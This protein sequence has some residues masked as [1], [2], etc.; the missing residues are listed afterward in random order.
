ME[1]P[2]VIGT[3]RLSKTLGIGAFGKARRGVKLAEHVTTGHKVAVK[4]LNRAKI[5]ALDMSEKVKREINILQRC[6]HPHII[7]LYEVIDTPTD[8]FVVME[9][10]SNGELFDYI[11]SKGRL[12]PDEA[13]HFFHQIISG[14]EYCHYHHIVHRD[15]K[16]ENLLLDADNNIKIADFGL[17]NVMR[18]GEFLR[19]SCGSPNYAAPEVISGHLYAGPEV[20]VWS[21][22]VILY[23]L[24]CGSLPFDDESIPNLFKKIKSGMYSLPSHLSQLARDLIPRMLVVDPMKRV[25]VPEV[26]GHAWFQQKLPPYLRHAP[27]RIENLERVID[28]DTA[29]ARVLAAIREPAHR[30]RG[31]EKAIRVAYELILDHKRTRLRTAELA[32]ARQAARQ[33]AAG[34]LEPA[35]ASSPAAR[36]RRR[37]A[38]GRGG[39]RDAAALR[40]PAPELRSGSARAAP[41]AR[42]AASGARRL[43][44][45]PRRRARRAVPPRRARRRRRAQAARAAQRRRWY[46]GIQSKKDP[47]HV[48]TEVYK[49]LLQ[50]DC[51]WKTVD[52]Y[53]LQTRWRPNAA[54]GAAGAPPPPSD[55]TAAND[56]LKSGYCIKIM[57]TLY[58]VQ[59]NIFLLD[60]QNVEGDCFGFMTLCAKIIKELKA[61]SAASRAAIQPPDGRRARGAAAAPRPGASNSHP[62]TDLKS[63]ST[64]LEWTPFFWTRRT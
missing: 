37:R 54:P 11:V 41:G 28:E 16:P 59:Q 3:Y 23:A 29:A 36:R 58:K 26:R 57:L 47:A 12:A 60:F 34:V 15:L 14:V 21:C 20:D 56:R 44:R 30:V 55:A 27:D 42:A 53:R 2:V 63:S 49:A 1:N 33:H 46:L 32:L 35:P 48:M 40:R 8:I 61:L 22:G 25:T 64:W 13:R 9:Y 18:D 38:A 51:E 62:P 39:G 45:R 6:T 10:V 17:S 50:L 4:I 43:A 5:V 19:T 31:V 52:P 24:L 7:R